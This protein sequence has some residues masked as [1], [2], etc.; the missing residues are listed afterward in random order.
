L[1]VTVLLILVPDAVSVD[2]EKADWPAMAKV[3]AAR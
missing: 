2:R 1:T 3:I